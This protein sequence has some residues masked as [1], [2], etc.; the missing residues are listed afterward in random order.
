MV[1]LYV[2]DSFIFHSPAAVLAFAARAGNVKWKQAQL[3]ST[4]QD[5]LEEYVETTFG[6]Y[7]DEQLEEA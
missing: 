6:C 1:C 5:V 7:L 2:H 3:N 4:K